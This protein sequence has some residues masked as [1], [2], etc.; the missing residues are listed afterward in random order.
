MEKIEFTIHRLRKPQSEM[1]RCSRMANSCK[2][3]RQRSF[4]RGNLLAAWILVAAFFPCPGQQPESPLV[5]S[6]R[7]HLQHKKDSPFG[8]E[9][10]PLG[11]TSNSALVEAFQV[12]TQHPGTIFLGF[13]SGNLWKTTN[14]GLTWKPVFENQPSYSVGDVALAPSNTHIIYLGTGETL[15]KPR[16]FTMPGTGMYRS[17]DGGETWRHIGLED[18]WHISKISVHPANPDIVFVA[19]VGHLWTTNKNRG[20]FRTLDGGKTWEHV[21]YVNDRTGA[22]DVV[23]APTDPTILYASVWESYPGVSGATSAIYKSTDAGKTW[24]KSD[25]GLPPGKGRGRIGLA[26]SH[27]NPEKAYALMDHRGKAEGEEPAW[28]A[29]EVYQTLDGGKSWKRTHREELMIFSTI[30]W[31]FADIVIDPLNDDEVY[32]LGVRLAHSVDGGKTFKLVGGDVYHLFPNPAEPLHL[33]Q[34]ELWINPVNP[35]HLALANDGGFYMSYDR[36]ANWMHFNNLPTGEFYDITLD[37]KKP[38][39]IYG[40]TQDNATVYSQGNEWIPKRYDNWH[41]LWIDPWS[42]GD[43]CITVIDPIDSAT[44][45]FSSQEGGIRRMNLNTR[46][47]E[48]AQPGKELKT[49]LKYNFIS[50]YFLSAFNHEQLYLGANFVMRSDNQGR[51][52]RPISPELSS[53][54]DKTRNS[55][56]ISAL[57]ESPV[58]QGLIYAGTDRGLFWVTTNDGGNWT[59]HSS[60]L[61]NLYVRTITPSKFNAARVYV[62]LSGINYD[63]FGTYLFTSEDCGKTW[64]K[65]TGNLPSEISY[66]IKEDPQHED[67]LYAG[68]YRAVYISLDRGRNWAQFGTGMPAAAVSD[69]EIDPSSRDLLVSTHG[70]GIYKVNLGPLAEWLAG[71]TVQEKDR[72][73]NVGPVHVPNPQERPDDT[74]SLVYE[75]LP[76]SFWLREPGEVSLGIVNEKNETV[77]STRVTGRRGFNQYRWDLIINRNDSPLPY[78]LKYSEFLPKGRY[79]IRLTGRTALEGALVAVD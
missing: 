32:A 5:K 72:L 56:A 42:G 73:L 21:L 67:V 12:D 19:A 51:D 66:T 29:A 54:K 64:K 35:K 38:Y 36:G 43:G 75:K 71:S 69:I 40:G 6:Y 55:L 22:N 47:S 62:A 70:R 53:G 61:P 7:E 16:N 27:R 78:F 33:D 25:M 8:L 2:Q 4:L 77:W 10:I 74:N 37:G 13:G 28:G 3:G 65:I 24:T 14:N 48:E 39:T 31:Y 59:E 52:W 76:I 44:I 57:A 50:P 79:T 49:P 30:G 58:K 18:A 17:D 68:L 15:K 34:C 26:V 1:K 23:M 63:D 11:P 46:K 60:G 41:Y 9:W 20:I 45:Y